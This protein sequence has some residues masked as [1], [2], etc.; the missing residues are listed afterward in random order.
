MPEHPPTAPTSVNSTIS[1]PRWWVDALNLAAA[2]IVLA[3]L[4]LDD[5]RSTVKTTIGVTVALLLA[6][7]IIALLVVEPV[8]ARVRRRHP[9]AEIAERRRLNSML[10]ALNEGVVLLDKAG[11]S[12]RWNS[13]ATRI[14][15]LTPA[16]MPDHTLRDANWM[17]LRP[18]GT[19]IGTDERPSVITLRTGRSVSNMPMGVRWSDGTRR[20]ISKSSVG[21]RDARGDLESVVVS[22]S[23]V[24][25]QLD[26]ERR[27]DV[28]IEA[29]GL[30][31]WD[32]HVPDGKVV[33]NARAARMLGYEPS[34]FEPNVS[35][36]DRLLHP[37]DRDA[38]FASLNAHLEGQSES[39]HCE[40][41]MRRKDGAWTWILGSGKVT[42]RSASGAPIRMNGVNVDLSAQKEA[43][44]RLQR[45]SRQLEE[46]QAVARMGSW[47]FDIATGS[48]EWSRQTFD[49]FG[50]DA[51]AGPPDY[52]DMLYGYADED[53]ARLAQ[54]I[55][56]AATAG[57]PYSLILKTRLGHNDVRFVRGE[58]RA[59]FDADGVIVGLFGTATDVTGAVEHEAALTKAR[60]EAEAANDKL[61]EINEVLEQATAR[62]NDTAR[63]AELAS[64]AKSE[65]LANMSHEIRTPLTAILGYTDILRDE[66]TDDDASARRT[67]AIHTIRR[68]GTHLLSVIND[69]LDLSKIEAG[70]MSLETIEMSLPRLFIDVDSL[71]R[72]RAAEKGVTLSTSL[73]T[74]IPDFVIGDPTRVRQ[75]LMN[76][77]GNAAKFTE[78]G[79][80]D[81]RAMLVTHGTS[82]L[83]RVEV[84]D[85]G[86]GMTSEQ[87]SVLFQPFTQADT[88]VTRKHGGTGLGLAICQRLAEMMD[89]T[90]RLDFTAPGRGSR[91]VFEVP[92]ALR[93]DATYVHDLDACRDSVADAAPDG[94]SGRT[95]N[96]LPTLRGRIL[97]AE[98]GEDNQRLITFHLTKAGADVTIASDGRMALD[99]LATAAAAG[100]PFDLLVTDMQMPVIDGYTLARTIRAQHL[101]I[102]IIAL[103]AHAMAEDRQKCLEA[104]CDDYASKPIDKALLIL[105]CARWMHPDAAIDDVFPAA[106]D[107]EIL[108][109]DLADDPDMHGLIDQFLLALVNHIATLEQL[110]SSGDAGGI[111]RVAHQLKGSAGGYGFSPISDAA[112]RVEHAANAVAA[113]AASVTAVALPDA[114]PQADLAA[115]LS[116]LLTRCRAAIR[117][118]PAHVPSG[119]RQEMF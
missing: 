114:G 37:E 47:S 76:M 74:P 33:W 70:R 60:A 30:G 104:G 90:V 11:T 61:L 83:L 59:R 23:D 14:L 27:M 21:V 94:V 45:T 53:S 16:Q 36:W 72:A 35:V 3:L 101:T 71:M 67:E 81:V 13:A 5:S 88:S 31:A 10:E 58:G 39:Y 19:P 44:V 80:I 77:V 24:T 102:P 89:G 7:P 96:A 86:P 65:F 50:R 8:I 56:E 105:T 55:T 106:M 111:A 93:D 103:T 85:T 82:S 22:I 20:W 57:L 73:T 79:R 40:F 119:V 17:Y 108:R 69:I 34:E 117:G 63:Q 51:A 115:G 97:L 48:I 75:I 84:E 41:R 54:S 100:Q 2:V 98:D 12:I 9:A 68:A 29:S 118:L 64:Q 46:A 6:V 52:A 113:T 49:L 38:T 66:L 109:S 62:A 87:A 95:A 116:L 1:G 112:L 43:E 91:F 26:R 4:G 99:L 107:N 28:I 15:G 42:E 78:H 32:W 25:E 92:M 18:D 110:V